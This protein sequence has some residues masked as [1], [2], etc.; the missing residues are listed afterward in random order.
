M[1]SVFL[2]CICLGLFPFPSLFLTHFCLLTTHLVSQRA[3]RYCP[4]PWGLG[5]CL[6]L[7]SCVT[8]G[9]SFCLGLWFLPE[10]K[11]PLS[12]LPKAP[13][14][15]MFS[16]IS[17]KSPASSVL[18]LCSAT[19]GLF[20]ERQ[21][22]QRPW[23]HCDPDPPQGAESCY[24]IRALLNFYLNTVFKN[25]PRKAAELRILKSLS[26][27]ANNFIVIL[28]KLRPSVSKTKLGPGPTEIVCFERTPLLLSG[29]GF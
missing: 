24:L 13:S 16:N 9:K 14:D 22:G 12:R 26:T 17:W 29:P 28:S 15:L 27:L 20:I 5:L 19:C 8:L 23:L 10:T 4:E 7:T 18:I 21:G 1:A 3:H 6:P 2:F 25:Y 11:G